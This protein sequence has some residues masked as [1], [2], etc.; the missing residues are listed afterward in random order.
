M[1]SLPDTPPVDETARETHAHQAIDQFGKIE[2]LGIDYI[3]PADRHGRPRELFA[4]WLSSNIAYIYILVG[5]LLPVL[6]LSIWQ[7]LAVLALGNLFWALVGFLAVSGPSAGSP[8]EIITRAM[9]GAR[10]NRVFGAGVNWVVC[11][12]YE[13]IN[14]A[15]GALG[16]FALMSY[17][18]IGTSPLVKVVVA[19]IIGVVTFTI[20]VYG[21]ATIVRLSTWIW[22]LL[23][24]FTLVLGVFV[25]RH[26]HLHPAGLKPLE[27]SA[28]WASLLIGFTAVAALPLSWGTGADYARYLPQSASMRAVAG[29]TAFGGWLPSMLLGG[30]GVLAGSVI[31]MN[32]PQI[33][34]RH[35][36]PP[37]FYV[38]FLL[39]LVIGS[40]TNNALTA[41]S[42]GLSL[43]AIG[44]RIS[45]A[46]SVIADAVLGGAL[47]AFALASSSFL[48]AMNNVLAFTVTFLGPS[49]AIYAADIIMRR[50]RYH[51]PALHDVSHSS[52]FWFR[53][54]VNWSGVSA[55]LAGTAVALLCVNTTLF[56]GPV[57]TA[58]GGGDISSLAGPL[59]G[60]VVYAG[61]SL[62]L[63]SHRA[64]NR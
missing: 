12:A 39:V 9:Y 36:V 16:G 18:G 51:G 35:I 21:H 2:S 61:L 22:G 62:A 34:M 44:V 59:V 53:G 52:P 20:S 38:I 63:G 47:C 27:G 25:A 46:R 64:G 31:D 24:A 32:D 6:G 49:L 4:V 30:I 23:G 3:S 26:A 55:L 54:G 10:G 45:R 41:Y 14:L 56:T 29:W 37:W 15:V 42:S 28:L 1:T 11:I 50:N 60:A 48:T 43:Q 7:S 17:L 40:I 8:S 19:V 58:L 57:A 33:S 13:G 5:G